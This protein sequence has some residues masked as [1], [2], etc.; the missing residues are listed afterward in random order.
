MLIKATNIFT[1]VSDS[2]GY[3]EFEQFQRVNVKFGRYSSASKSCISDYIMA[4]CTVK[5]RPL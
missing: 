2:A 4:E 1:E 3:A 5:W